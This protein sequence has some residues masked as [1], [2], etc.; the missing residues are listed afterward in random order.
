MMTEQQEAQTA[1]CGVDV[2]AGVLPGTPEPEFTRQW[3]ITSAEW[4]AE[5]GKNQAELLSDMAG[6]AAAWATYI[7]LQP[8]RFNWVKLEWVWF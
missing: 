8:D 6:K 5:E 2:V 4:Y 7:M 3:F 1:K